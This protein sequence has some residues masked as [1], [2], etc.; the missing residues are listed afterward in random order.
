MLKADRAILSTF[1]EVL[2]SFKI[3]K[4]AHPGLKSDPGA[5][6]DITG[7]NEILYNAVYLGHPENEKNLI[8]ELKS[9]QCDLGKPL[10]VWNIFPLC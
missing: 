3:N 9:L 7:I 4:D 1:A 6:I 5:S 2:K 10:T 8:E